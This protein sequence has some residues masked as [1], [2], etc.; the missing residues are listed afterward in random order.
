MKGLMSAVPARP[1][2]NH[3]GV[4]D[5]DVE[6]P[7]RGGQNLADEAHRRTV[8]HEVPDVTACRDALAFQL[9]DALVDPGRG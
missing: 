6:P 5:E 7:V 1:D 3:P 4:I 9:G 8:P 2:R